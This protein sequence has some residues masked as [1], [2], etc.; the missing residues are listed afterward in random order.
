MFFSACRRIDFT[1][2][3]PHQD[4]LPSEELFGK[5]KVLSAIDNSKYIII[6]KDKSI[7]FLLKDSTFEYKSFN[8]SVS[9]EISD[10]RISH[11]LY[12]WYNYTIENGILRIKDDSNNKIIYSCV[13]DTTAPNYNQW[14]HI[15]T[16]SDSVEV[17]QSDAVCDNEI[18]FDGTNILLPKV[19]YSH[20]YDF[21]KYNIAKRQF[22]V[23][24][25]NIEAENPT[26]IFAKNYY[27]YS[28]SGKEFLIKINPANGQ[29][30]AQTSSSYYTFGKQGTSVS[31][32]SIILSTGFGYLIYTISNDSWSTHSIGTG[33]GPIEY[34][35]GYMYVTDGY[36]MYKIDTKTMKAVN[37]YYFSKIKNG[38]N[39]Y[40]RGLT[41]DGQYFW[42]N[43][44]NA[45]SQ[46][47]TL[48]KFNIN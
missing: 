31:G 27:W 44:Y 12:Y 25:T 6:N 28:V 42:I 47:R 36:F 26:V 7:Y 41:Y 1:P 2:P 22:T 13:K 18:G 35:A 24:S 5:W 40:I 39:N 17:P 15:L 4:F 3:T 38:V 10:T 29:R 46:G 20:N 21:Y 37:S 11:G 19:E 16:P 14:V 43:D 33:L 23:L 34:V 32:D 30:V 9:N 45:A 8:E 48:Y